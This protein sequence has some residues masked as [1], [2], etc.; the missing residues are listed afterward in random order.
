MND[1]VWTAHE[2]CVASINR[3]AKV[4]S[5]TI[6]IGNSTVHYNSG[7]NNFIF[8]PPPGFSVFSADTYK[9]ICKEIMAI[10]LADVASLDFSDMDQTEE[11]KK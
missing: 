7:F 10:K 3:L 5:Y 4:V 2:T 6:K 8:Q 9:E 11:I 1:K